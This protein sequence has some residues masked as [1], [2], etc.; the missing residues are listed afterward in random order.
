MSLFYKKRPSFYH[1]YIR[2]IFNTIIRGTNTGGSNTLRYGIFSFYHA[3]EIRLYR[4]F[5]KTKNLPQK[6]PMA[7]FF[8]FRYYC[9]ASEEISSSYN[10]P[11]TYWA[12][13]NRL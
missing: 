8:G 3:I 9:F 1:L 4:H 10:K 11:Y 5:K 7:D 12:W 13:C 6:D 2:T